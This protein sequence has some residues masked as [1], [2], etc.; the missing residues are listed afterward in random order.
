MVASFKFLNSSPVTRVRLLNS[1]GHSLRMASRKAHAASVCCF[2]A[3]YEAK[4]EGKS[5]AALLRY[6]YIYV[7][8]HIYILHI[9]IYVSIYFYT[10]LAIQSATLS[11]YWPKFTNFKSKA[12]PRGHVDEGGVHQ[13]RQAAAS[14]WTTLQGPV[15]DDGNDSAP[16]GTESGC[17]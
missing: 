6:I 14:C 11:G 9:C 2:T 5:S 10:A 4:E 1:E 12:V 8:T 16:S 3:T 13:P 7:Y 17:C 15:V